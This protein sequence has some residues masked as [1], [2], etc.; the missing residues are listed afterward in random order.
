[1]HLIFFLKLSRKEV[2][3]YS[4]KMI[5]FCSGWLWPFKGLCMTGLWGIRS[6]S[7]I[8]SWTFRAL[9]IWEMTLL[10]SEEFTHQSCLSSESYREM[11]WNINIF[12]FW[13][14]LFQ[15]HKNCLKLWSQIFLSFIYQGFFFLFKREPLSKWEDKKFFFL[16]FWKMKV[17]LI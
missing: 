15:F 6:L 16:H 13:L 10:C 2:Q 9:E 11:K 3:S 4:S 7:W 14:H 17:K 5:K 8:W 12:F 1:M